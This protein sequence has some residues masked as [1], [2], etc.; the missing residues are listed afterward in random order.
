[1]AFGPLGDAD[2]KSQKGFIKKSLCPVRLVPGWPCT[3]LWSSV[4]WAALILNRQRLYQ[5]Q[6]LS[7]SP[8]PRLALHIPLVFCPL[9]G[10]DPKSQRAL[11]KTASVQ[12]T[13]SPASLAHPFGL[14][15]LALGLVRAHFI[16]EESRGVE[17]VHRQ[18]PFVRLGQGPHRRGETFS[19]P[20]H[21]L[22]QMLRWIRWRKLL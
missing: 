17:V 14:L 13:L 20:F 19:R 6:P 16:M 12:F 3:S 22:R 2:P 11:S 4:P 10:A 18:R 9:G 1:M 5:T 8:C 7:S 21:R 15:S